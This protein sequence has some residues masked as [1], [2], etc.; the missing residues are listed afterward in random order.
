MLQ[1]K[2][3]EMSICQPV[4]MLNPKLSLHSLKASVGPLVPHPAVKQ[5][6][7]HIWVEL[8]YVPAQD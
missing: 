8:L 6:L 5:Q 3:P 2:L 7:D 4:V 1:H